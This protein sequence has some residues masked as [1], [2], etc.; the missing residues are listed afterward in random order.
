MRILFEVDGWVFVLVIILVFFI[1]VG[2]VENYVL[3]NS[4]KR[5]SIRVIVNGTRGKS[6]VT[7][8]IAAGLRGG[9]YKVMAKTTGTK[10]RMVINNEVEVPVIRLG[11]ANIIEQVRIIKKA[12]DLGIQAL[13]LENMSLRPDLQYMEE[14]RIANPHVVVITNVRQDHLDVMGPTLKDI[15]RHFISA[16]PRGSVIFTAERELFPFLEEL[17]AKRN[18]RIFQALEEEVEEENM[19]GFTYFEHRENVAL[20]LKVCE[21][22]GVKREDALKEMY[23]YIPD[24]GVLRFYELYFSDKKV[25]FYNAMAANDPDSTFYIF[26]RIPKDTD[27]FY[28][29]MNCRSDRIDR[30]RQMAELVASKI[31]AKLIFVTGGATEVFVN[32]AIKNGIPASHIIDLGGRS[33]DDIFEE[34]GKN[35]EDNSIILA[36]GN[37]VGYGEKMVEYFVNRGSNKNFSSKGA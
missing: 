13:V 20:A 32:W 26:Q 30:S 22:F 1:F 23:R 5:I 31:P 3:K 14:S 9:G 10:P 29:L 33:Y 15:A 11:R 35:V 4:L 16:A 6:T 17:A 34:I 28:I 18:L 37:I 8:L 12:A 27:N 25:K 19:K 21:F 7:R 2:I 24:P 36:I